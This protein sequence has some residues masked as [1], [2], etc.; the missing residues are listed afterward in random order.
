MDRKWKIAIPVVAGILAIGT[1]LGVVAAKSTDHSAAVYQPA[2]NYQTASTSTAPDN[3]T[4]LWY[5]DA[6]GGMMGYG[7]GFPVTPQVATLLGTTTADLTAQLNSGKTLAEIASAQGITQDELIQAM[8]ARYEAH[9]SLMVQYGYLTQDQANSMTEQ[10]QE[11]LQTMV[12]SQLNY[13]GSGWNYYIGGM[14]GRYYGGD[15][16][17]QQP[18]SESVPQPGYGGMM[19]GYGSGMMRGYTGGMMG[20]W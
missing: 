14:M 2:G 18:G 15:D 9:L 19:G 13:D 20:S 12:T 4:G 1:G 10:V 11:R 3:T 8:M 17:Q 16:S 6:V 5:C 7:A